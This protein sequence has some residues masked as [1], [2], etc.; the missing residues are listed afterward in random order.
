MKTYLVIRDELECATIVAR[1][2]EGSSAKALYEAAIRYPDADRYSVA[3]L[4][5]RDWPSVLIGYPRY[6][7]APDPERAARAN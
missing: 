6:S 1:K 3:L 4:Y 2:V 7:D 5:G